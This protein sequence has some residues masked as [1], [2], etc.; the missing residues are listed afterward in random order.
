MMPRRVVRLCILVTLVIAGVV[1]FAQPSASNAGPL[2]PIELP[3]TSGLLEIDPA[4]RDLIVG[5]VSGDRFT[6]SL[7]WSAFSSILYPAPF[8]SWPLF[9]GD[10]LRIGG[11]AA[12][13]D[14]PGT[15]VLD[16]VTYDL[17]TFCLSGGPC[18]NYLLSGDVVLPS[19]DVGPVTVL[20]AEFDFSAGV[21]LGHNGPTYLF[22]GSGAAA[23]VFRELHNLPNGDPTWN[24]DRAAYVFTPP[25]PEPSTL[26]LLGSGLA[27]L[28]GVAWRRHRRR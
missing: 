20:S 25:V 24:F 7:A 22:P 1:Q 9:P 13:S 2:A 23:L 4:D 17:G 3:I 18:A 19:F 21:E 15:L 27:G 28:G 11:F 16:G 14:A 8:M 26:L 5:I 6:L 10:T 12:G